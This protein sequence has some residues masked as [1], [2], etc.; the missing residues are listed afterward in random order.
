M[1][2]EHTAEQRAADG[3]IRELAVTDCLCDWCSSPLRSTEVGG[4]YDK[5]IEFYNWC[6]LTM[7]GKSWQ[8]CSRRCRVDFVNAKEYQR[9][10]DEKPWF[11]SV[12]KG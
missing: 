6:S 11:D 10:S 8:L 2:R 1:I 9:S 3:S 4:D 7:E 5:V 12:E